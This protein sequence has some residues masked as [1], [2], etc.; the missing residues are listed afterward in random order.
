MVLLNDRGPGAR[1]HGCGANNRRGISP[2]PLR[3]IT[4]PPDRR[5]GPFAENTGAHFSSFTARHLVACAS[6]AR[7]VSSIFDYSALHPSFIKFFLL[8]LHLL[9]WVK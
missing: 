4:H 7:T 8:H 3:Y 5:T 9:L 6:A 2:I 1:R